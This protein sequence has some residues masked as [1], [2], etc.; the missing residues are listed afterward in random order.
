MF[1]IDTKF[2]L[3][4]EVV[5]PSNGKIVTYA[6]QQTTSVMLCDIFIDK[7]GKEFAEEMSELPLTVIFDKE[8]KPYLETLTSAQFAKHMQKMYGINT[9]SS[10]EED[11]DLEPVNEMPESDINETIN[12]EMEKVGVKHVEDKPVHKSQIDKFNERY[13]R[14]PQQQQPKIIKS[15]PKIEETKSSKVVIKPATPR[16]IISQPVQSNNST[17]I[18]DNTSEKRIPPIPVIKPLEGFNEF[19]EDDIDELINERLQ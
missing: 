5:T 14:Q 6:R 10:I 13:S 18:H 2:Y 1:K 8:S 7:D 12:S 3:I 11:M 4:G 15:E 9:S 17:V 19:P 16:P